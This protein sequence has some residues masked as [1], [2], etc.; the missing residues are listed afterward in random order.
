MAETLEPGAREGG[1]VPLLEPLPGQVAVAGEVAEERRA[2]PEPQP[3]GGLPPA[4][5]TQV[6]RQVAH[7]PGQVD[8]ARRRG[9]LGDVVHQDHRATRRHQ[10]A[11]V[12]QGR[13][14]VVQ[15]VEGGDAEDQVEPV[16]VDEPEQVAGKV[17]DAWVAAPPA[18]DVDQRPAEVD[19]HDLV[20]T[21][22]QR[23]GVAAGAAAGVQGP[24]APGR[25]VVKQPPRQPGRLQADV[26]V[27]AGR[28]PV[29]GP[30]VRGAGPV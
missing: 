10:P 3:P 1:A 17:A 4:V 2:G 24:P 23:Q 12:A 15:V 19:A 26:P 14:E 29:E 7:G 18:G 16:R 28:E 20:E 22:S 30:R 9:P 5:A 11:E 25:Q 8:P 6:A 13:V 21:V 27:V